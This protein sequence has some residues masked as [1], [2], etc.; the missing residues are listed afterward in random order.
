M[1]KLFLLL[2]IGI[3]TFYSCQ[4]TEV[5]P[6]VVSA[7]TN[8]DATLVKT[9]TSILISHPWMYKGFYFHYID[10]Q[11]KGDPEYVRGA[12]N[13][14]INLDETRFKFRSDGS[15]VELDG[16]YRY[17][18]TWNFTDNT[19]TV[20]IM[21]YSWGDDVCTFVNFNNSHINFTQPMGYNSLSYTELIP[22]Q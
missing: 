6:S 19:A 14:A 7:S 22:A 1:K 12:N 3:I 15:F 11:H 21:H 9:R 5:R 8:D 2:S 4:K 16:G 20:M 10:Q 13:N 17:P 18:G